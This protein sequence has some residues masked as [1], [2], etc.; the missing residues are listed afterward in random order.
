MFP[1]Y[2]SFFAGSA[3]LEDTS[4]GIGSFHDKSALSRIFNKTVK[5]AIGFTLG[6]TIV[7][8]ALGAFAGTVGSFLTQNNTIVNIITGLIVIFFG[9]HFTGIVNISFLNKSKK[10]D[11]GY[12]SPGF[13]SSALFGIVFSI[14]W[15][16][17]V[18]VFLGSA[19][20]LAASQ[21]GVLT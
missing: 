12:K 6:F 14:G 20:M 16:P 5:N 15:T 8:V 2:L 13:F 7:F 10:F 4:D 3:L 17:C 18:G 21:G 1:I 9:L 19:L 11:F